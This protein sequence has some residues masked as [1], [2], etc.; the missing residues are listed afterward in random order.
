MTAVDISVTGLRACARLA[1]AKGVGVAI[2]AA[3]LEAFDL[4]SSRWA[5]ITM[6]YYFQPTLFPAI[7]RS[8]EPGGRFYFQTFSADHPAVGDHGPRDP[9]FLVK[10]NEMLTALP[11]TRIRLYEDETVTQPDGSCEALIRLIAERTV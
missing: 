3:D 4:G 5:A 1:G 2:V 10:P 7:V 6:F 8:L 9:R 11:G